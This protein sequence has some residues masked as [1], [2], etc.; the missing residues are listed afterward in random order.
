[1]KKSVV[2]IDKFVVFLIILFLLFLFYRVFYVSLSAEV[3]GINIKKFIANRSTKVESLIANRGTI[4]TKDGSEILAEDINSYTVIAYLNE[5]RSI[6]YDKPQHVVDKKATAKALSSLID[7]SEESILKL[8]S[9]DSYQVE[10]GPGG[11]NISRLLKD[12]IQAL[13]LP[14]ISFST[15]VKRYYQKGDFLSYTLGYTNYDD[16]GV[17][18]GQMGLESKYNES[19][20]G[21][22]GSLEYQKDYYGYKL[23]NSKIIQ[24]DPKNGSDI[25]LTIDFQIQ[26]YL[27][28]FLKEAVAGAIDKEVEVTASVMEAKTGKILA[29]TSCP[30]FDPNVKNISSYINPFV[31]ATFE[32]GS[33]M[34][35]FTYMANMENGTYDENTT[36]KSGS[37]N[38]ADSNIK[39]WHNGGF[40]VI[41][42]KKGFEYSSNLGVINMVREDMNAK[43]LS[44]YFKKLGF[45]Q[46][47]G[48]ELPKESIGN[49]DF[50]YETE[51]ATA[52]FGQGITTTSIQQLQAL[53]SVSND[54]I[55]LKPYIIEKIIDEKGNTTYE[56][57]KTELGRVA[58][59]DTVNKIRNL[60]YDVIH[61]DDQ[62]AT[63][64]SYKVSE[65]DL[66]GKTGTAQVASN[67]GGYSKKTYIKSF[68]GM[69]P[70]DDPEIVITISSKGKDV[71][72]GP[73]N[74]YVITNAVK[75]IAKYLDKEVVKDE[76]F[77]TVTIDN[78]INTD[79]TSTS[80]KLDGQKINYKV[81]GS[82]E[83]IIAQ[84]PKNT[85]DFIDTLYLIT[86]NEN[87]QI[88][89]TGMSKLEATNICNLT[90]SSCIFNGI[91]YVKNSIFENNTYTL[92]FEKR[93]TISNEPQIDNKDK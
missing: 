82:G 71:S 19:L 86:N 51:I 2:Q 88:D 10:L 44:D 50:T 25:Y 48:I 26:F 22:N 61:S 21:I 4:Y 37:I 29:T 49:I 38:I 30:S 41:D 42:Y 9:K 74:K 77:E 58:S 93:F 69:F 34:K 83:K 45:G 13:N 23:P 33:I 81:I 59:I 20:T 65:V 68:V 87:V 53:T 79:I 64:K 6:N 57:M 43:V 84:Y 27:E 8:L 14:G 15:S 31:E 54:G 75:A 66:I 62:F 3:G 85:S 18:K 80:S 28:Q 1:M 92:T 76:I 73:I 32:P 12:E 39:D 90:K 55:L 24:I 52:S 5:K 63:G 40:G 36:F 46:K 91:G 11:R 70:K 60:M 16:D 47:T 78:Y 89:F 17:L 56:G 72:T 7:M 67:T 35:I